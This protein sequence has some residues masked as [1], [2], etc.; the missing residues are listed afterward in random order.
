MHATYIACFTE[1]DHSVLGVVRCAVCG[2]ISDRMY[3][4]THEAELNEIAALHWVRSS[5]PAE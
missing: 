5:S 4:D 3:L 1:T 2:P